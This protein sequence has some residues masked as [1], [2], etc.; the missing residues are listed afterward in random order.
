NKVCYWFKAGKSFNDRLINTFAVQFSKNIFTTTT[1]S[2]Q[3]VQAV[4][5]SF[6]NMFFSDLINLSHT[7]REK[8]ELFSHHF[9]DRLSKKEEQVLI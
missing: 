8:Q 3:V 4:S 6:F 5:T 7:L 2:Y 1:S 9:R